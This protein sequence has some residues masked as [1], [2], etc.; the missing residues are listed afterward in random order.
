MG[1]WTQRKRWSCAADLNR[2]I[3]AFLLSGVLVGNF[4]SVV[5]VLAG[6]MGLGYLAVTTGYAVHGSRSAKNAALKT[7]TLGARVRGG[8]KLD[9]KMMGLLESIKYPRYG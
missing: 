8:P 6:S 5:L 2:R 1:P 3:L 9:H 7:S 4:S